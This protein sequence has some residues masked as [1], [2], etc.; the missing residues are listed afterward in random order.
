[1]LELV[2]LHPNASLSLL[3]TRTPHLTAVQWSLQLR[4]DA[5]SPWHHSAS[6]FLDAAAIASALVPPAAGLL[7]PAATLFLGSLP[8]SL[9]HGHTPSPP[10]TALSHTPTCRQPLLRC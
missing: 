7:C 9:A 8:R 5:A 2:I 1:M 3:V 4:A 10:H 6:S